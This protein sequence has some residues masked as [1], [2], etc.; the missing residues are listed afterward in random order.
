MCKVG[1][2]LAQLFNQFAN[3]QIASEYKQ[4]LLCS[5]KT[6]MNKI[7]FSLLLIIGPVATNAQIGNLFK[8]VKDKTV[9]KVNTR[10]DQKI[11]RAIDKTL[12]QAEGKTTNNRNS[13]FPKP[14]I[15][16]E[17][18]QSNSGIAAYN[19]YD[20]VPGEKIIYSND[21]VQD[22]MG[23]LPIGWNTSGT[24]AVAMF[25][26][27]P[28]RWVQLNQNSMYLTDNKNLFGEDFTVEFDLM[29]RRTNT[30]ALFPVLAFGVLASGEYAPGANELLKEYAKAFA[31][32]LKI[33]PSDNNGSHMHLHTYHQTNMYLITDVKQFGILEQYFNKA[34]HVAMQVQKER[35]RIWFN[36]TKLY[37][38]PK[39]I[40]PGTNI[41]QLYFNVK[42][43]GGPDAE[44]GY[45]ISNIK[46]A[47]GL[48]DTR[49]KLI[50]EGKFSTTGILFDVNSANIK[51]E[52][53]G[54]LKEIA[55]VLKQFPDIRIKIIGHTDNDGSDI[56]NLDLSK[57]R[58]VAV[59]QV[60]ET[61]F[62]IDAARIST[63]GK[64][65]TI[66]IGE[67]KTREGK[68]QNRRVEFLKQ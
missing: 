9:T 68:A 22:A 61:D 49:H 21:F 30:K 4:K 38:L 55:E 44:V 66:P 3:I 57:K 51:P 65:E 41:N 13:A 58:A 32:E 40:V 62:G 43:Y 25:S 7:L 29:L 60:L 42:R 45:A 17:P 2:Q 12:D 31:T 8:K 47:K 5:L 15:P 39:A 24:G 48:P 64:G 19:K 54:A 67:N 23:E 53:N 35:L 36:E 63:D 34:I 10:I 18:M 46:A 50:E 28:G 11:D 26:G 1:L 37:D 20:F 14:E 6:V 59:K 33:Q 16:K 27:L 52:S 56:D